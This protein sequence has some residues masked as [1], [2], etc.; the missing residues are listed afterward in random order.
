MKL[1]YDHQIFTLQNYGGISR[2]FCELM[3]QL[4]KSSDIEFDLALRHSRNEN[5]CNRP[6]LNQHWPNRSKFLCDTHVFSAIQK[7][8]HVNVLNCLCLNKIESIRLLK[9]QDFDVFHPTYYDPYFLR[10]LRKKP[11]V[12]TVYDMTHELYPDY[13]P[14]R[15]STSL[16]KKQVIQ[17]ADAIIAI[18]ENTKRDLVKYMDVEPERVT[19]T[20]LGNPFEYINQSNQVEI[21]F[22]HKMFEKS[23]LLFVGNRSGY[24]NFAFFI[25]SITKV[26]KSHED[27][28]VY[29]VGG[30]PFTPEELR[31]FDQLDILS[32]VRFVKANDLT[33]K[34]LYEN[35]RAFIFP[36]IY[37]GFGL[38]VLEAFSC[39]CP[40]ILSNSSSLPE[41]GS[42]A[43][44]YFDPTD[45]E[46]LIQSVET[47][48]SDNSCR[49]RLIK[50]GFKRLNLFSWEETAEN[51]KKVYDNVVYQ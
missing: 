9:K 25:Q 29:C 19:V 43:A 33:M 15:D 23:Y 22:K 50:K 48:L 32:K 10:Y 13:F 44:I 31:L 11:F 14:P 26:L 30:G 49:E 42:D 2:Y 47:V 1:L 37:E 16:Q 27:L 45:S 35:A 6:S 40:T 3:D 24:K 38:P 7:I 12:L 36:S 41:I 18:S 34:H 5:L 8:A 39:G 4:S 51:T 17:K 28:S 46:S 20:Y 21:D